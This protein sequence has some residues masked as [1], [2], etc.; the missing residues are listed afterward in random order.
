[1]HVW[2]T[3]LILNR[4]WICLVPL[5]GG[6]SVD[7]QSLSDFCMCCPDVTYCNRYNIT[8]KKRFLFLFLNTTHGKPGPH[9]C[10]V[11]IRTQTML[12]ICKNM[13]EIRI[14]D[15]WIRF[16]CGLLLRN[17][18]YSLYALSSGF[19]QNP[20][21]GSLKLIRSYFRKKVTCGISLQRKTSYKN[22]NKALNPLKSSYHIF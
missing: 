9:G 5:P 22:C 14:P 1:M 17:Y 3:V 8:K 18:P 19:S 13:R 10:S 4:C 11:I 2:T 7:K 6:W 21:Q 12:G 20:H 15:V 16:C